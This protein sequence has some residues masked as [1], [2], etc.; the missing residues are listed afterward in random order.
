[1]IGPAVDFNSINLDTLTLRLFKDEKLVYEG[2]S[3]N[4]LSSPWNI[5][6]WIAN[7]LVKRGKNLNVGDVILCGKVA[8]AVK[9]KPKDAI[10]TYRGECCGLGTIRCNVQ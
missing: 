7:D 4:T 9:L 5:M 1:M 3:T 2:I 6:L 10:G 8:S